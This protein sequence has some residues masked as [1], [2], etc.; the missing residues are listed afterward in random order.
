[1][2]GDV[3]LDIISKLMCVRIAIVTIIVIII[4]LFFKFIWFFKIGIPLIIGL[5]LLL[6]IK[7]QLNRK[8]EFREFVE[9]RVKNETKVEIY[10]N[11]YFKY[12]IGM[13]K[14]AA[15]ILILLALWEALNI[16]L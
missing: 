5:A 1:V 3:V 2:K 8:H 4:T 14:V 11:N 15:V 7:Y 6:D 16:V 10:V 9:L 12:I 13:E